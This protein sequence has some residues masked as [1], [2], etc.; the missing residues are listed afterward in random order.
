[1][2][3]QWSTSS[4][5]VKTTALEVDRFSQEVIERHPETFMTTLS[6]DWALCGGSSNGKVAKYCLPGCPGYVSGWGFPSL[7]SPG[8]G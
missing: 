7:R 1:M 8:F 5:W 4:T 3:Y 6:P 2:I